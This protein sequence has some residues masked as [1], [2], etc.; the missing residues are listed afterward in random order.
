MF[1]SIFAQD[2]IANSNYNSMQVSLDKR[3]AHG[4]QFTLAYT[5]SKSLT[6][7]LVNTANSNNANDIAQQYGPSY[8]NRPQRFVVN[9]SY[10]LPFGKG[11]PLGLKMRVSAPRA[12]SSR[13]ASSVRKRLKDRSR[14][15]P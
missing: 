3:F 8:F 1:S 6:N 10:D 2:T 12:S 5:Y 9:Y 4:L 13:A 7:S 15:E 14:S 11:K